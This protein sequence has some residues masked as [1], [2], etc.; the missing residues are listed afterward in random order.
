[1]YPHTHTPSL[2]FLRSIAAALSADEQ[3]DRMEA[4]ERYNKALATI[5][6]GV[7]SLSSSVASQEDSASMREIR[8]K[9]N[10]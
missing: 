3:Q 1:M 5:R 7:A 2:P 4:L 10:R 8:E 6:S 9:M